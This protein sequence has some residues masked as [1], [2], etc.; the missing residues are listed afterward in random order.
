MGRTPKETR[1]QRESRLSRGAAYRE[2]KR[3]AD[4]DGYR[5]HLAAR[6][7]RYVAAHPERAK[8]ATK[9]WRD[10]NRP[11]RNELRRAWRSRN[12]VKML[13]QE[14]KSRAKASGREFT[15][16]LND[17][18]QMGDFCPLLGHP[19]PPPD[20]RDGVYSPSL[21][22]IDSSRGYVPGNVWI[23]GRRAN[24]LKNDGTAAEHEAI[25]AAMRRS[26]GAL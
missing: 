15:I 26:G 9:R 14:A 2:R 4:P 11:R 16:A 10:S 3:A 17:I 6:T 5:A 23:V 25:A 12:I 8:A 20:V 18:P 21:D 19:F 7:R 1:E 13:F 24:R 22:R